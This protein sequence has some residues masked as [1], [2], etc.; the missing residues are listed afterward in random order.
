MRHK[1]AKFKSCSLKVRGRESRRKMKRGLHSF[2]LLLSLFLRGQAAD[3][4]VLPFVRMCVKYLSSLSFMNKKKREKRV[5]KSNV[6]YKF[7]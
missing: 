4:G 6:K 5:R 3:S 1:N 2:I 7:T